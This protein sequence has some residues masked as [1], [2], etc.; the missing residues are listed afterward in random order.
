LR[1]VSAFIAERVSLKP[2]VAKYF[3]TAGTKSAALAREA[4]VETI[5]SCCCFFAPQQC[6]RAEEAPAAKS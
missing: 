1:F 2:F 4:R 5:L 3:S 6:G